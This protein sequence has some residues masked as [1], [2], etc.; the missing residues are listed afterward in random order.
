MDDVDNKE[1]NGPE[2][3]EDVVESTVQEK[4]NQMGG[5]IDEDVAEMLIEYEKNGKVQCAISDIKAG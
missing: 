2:K 1:S 4:I 3:V 5:L